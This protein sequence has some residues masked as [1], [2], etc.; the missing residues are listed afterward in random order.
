MPYNVC[1]CTTVDK[2][3]SHKTYERLIT[4]YANNVRGW[5][6]RVVG[7]R[8]INIESPYNYCQC[9]FFDIHDNNSDF[10]N[11]IWLEIISDDLK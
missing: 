11:K 4:F 2:N 5:C 9:C 6:I 10:E 1:I 3:N 7:L 8:N